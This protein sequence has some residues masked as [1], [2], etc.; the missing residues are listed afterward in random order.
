M[1]KLIAWG[2]LAATAAA[3][4]CTAG[5]E[6]SSGVP[7]WQV[8]QPPPKR[9]DN[10]G[11][12]F[13]QPSTNYQQ[14]SSTYQPPAGSNTGSTCPA[15]GTYSCV[16][17]DQ[18]GMPQTQIVVFVPEQ[19]GGGC[20]VEGV[21]ALRCGGTVILF[22]SDG[23]SE[24]VGSWSATGSTIIVSSSQNGSTTT[25]TPTTERPPT[26]VGGGTLADGG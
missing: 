18:N 11:S 17:T 12:T 7:P 21:V 15:C 24:V 20:N 26:P 1:K 23:G 2:A 9:G 13:Q 25:C 14:P 10:P 3:I 16:S 22:D 4:A 6:K 19:G 8:Y 5:S